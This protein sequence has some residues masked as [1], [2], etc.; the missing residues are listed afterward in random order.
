MLKKFLK[1][2]Y[3]III[4]LLKKADLLLLSPI[5]ILLDA[6]QEMKLLIVVFMKLK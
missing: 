4:S 2:L 5:V 6:L 1:K 3:K